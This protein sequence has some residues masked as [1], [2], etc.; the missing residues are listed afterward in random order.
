MFLKLRG[1]NSTSRYWCKML[2]YVISTCL[3]ELIADLCNPNPCLNSGTCFSMSYGYRCVCDN[4]FYGKQ[5]EFEYEREYEKTNFGAYAHVTYSQ[6]RSQRG[7]RGH[8][9]QW[10]IEWIFY[11]KSGLVL[12]TGSILSASNMPKM[13]WRSSDRLVGRGEVHSL[14][15]HHPLGASIIAPSALSFCTPPHACKIM[16]TSLHTVLVRCCIVLP[17]SSRVW[18]FSRN[19]SFP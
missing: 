15:N 6:G 13:R 3:F 18:C 1:K 5:C 17:C 16:A 9:P 4:S 7:P 11:W 2:R 10:S 19:M 14:P 8:G 12:P